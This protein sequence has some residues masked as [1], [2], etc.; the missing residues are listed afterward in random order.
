MIRPARRGC[1]MKRFIEGEGRSQSGLFPER[2]DRWIAEDHPVRAVDALVDELDSGKLGL[3]SVEPA[4]TGC[5]AHHPGT[6]LKIYEYGYRKRI[7][8][9]RLLER[10]SR[11]NVELSWP[12]GRLAPAFESI[13]DFRQGSGRGIRQACREFVELCREIGLST[14]ALVAINGSK[15][16]AVNNRDKNFTPHK[17]MARQQQLRQGVA[18]YLAELDPVDRDRSPV[19]K[20]RV[21]RLQETVRRKV[22]RLETIAEG[23]AKAVRLPR[24]DC[25]L[26]ARCSLADSPA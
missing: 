25:D 2:L 23:L 5:K 6:L 1:A 17:P 7:Q 9:S 16:K 4:A 26:R 24:S 18:R 20:E 11:R 3:D 10:D 21:A 12:T 14:Q 8:R 13:A 15:F 19:P 22:K